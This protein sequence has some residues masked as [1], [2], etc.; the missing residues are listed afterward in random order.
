MSRTFWPFAIALA[1]ASGLS[2]LFW[3]GIDHPT[4][5]P[6]LA[7][8][9]LVL[10]SVN[11]LALAAAAVT[12]VMGVPRPAALTGGNATPRDR[13]AILWLICGEPPEPLAVRARELVKALQDRP[14]GANTQVFILS[15]TTDADA[16]ANEQ[17]LFAA[18]PGVIY[19]NRTA[20]DGRK[21]GNLRNWLERYGAEFDTMLVLDADSSF[22]A[23]RLAQMRQTMAQEPRLALL[24]AG[25]ALR[26]GS[27]RLARLQRLSVRMTGPVFTSG[28]ARLSGACGN[29]WG[30]NALLR[31]EAFRAVADLP[32]LPGRPPFGGPIL[33]HDFI[34][35]AYLRAAGWDL[36][37]CP[38]ML[39]SAEDAPTTTAA[40][41]R[42]D[43]R[44]AQGNLQHLRLIGARGLHPGSRLH[45]LAGIQ[46]YISAPIWLAL[47]LL[48]GSG[49]V[50]ARPEAWVALAATLTVLLVPKL[51]GLARLRRQ[52]AR[53]PGP[54]LRG[55]GA[56]LVLST[57]IAPI[58]MLR[59]AG[60]VLSVLAG[61][62]GGW[63]PSGA[64]LAPSG[65][66][67]RGAQIAGL[68]ILLAVIF[69]QAL[70]ASAASA[71]LSAAMV[72]PVVGPLLAAPWLLAWL[73]DLAR[74]NHVAAYYDASTKRFL[75]VGGS[76][77]ALAIHR[78]LWA[79]GV[80][81]S[82]Q[83]AA[84][85][86]TLIAEATER[87]L[88]HPPE[89][90]C[91][92]G[93]GVGG[94]MFHLAHLWPEAR[95]SGLTLSAEQVRLARSHARAQG[96]SDR[97][98]FLQADF[99]LHASL[100]KAEVAIAVESHVHAP[101]AKAFLTAALDHL[102]PGGVL[103]LV[104]DMLAEERTLPPRHARLIDSFRKG[105]RLGHVSARGQIA[106]QAEALGYA[107]LAE[108]D[109]SAF[110]HLTRW[111][112]RALR[113][114]GP[115]A[116]RFGLHH[117]PLFANMIGG[118]ALTE[119]YRHGLMRY[120]LLVLRAPHAARLPDDRSETAA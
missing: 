79:D 99:T 105:W 52:I 102:A 120:T 89:H 113:V 87:M 21:P 35:A 95:F 82:E 24:Q 109:L 112:D 31:V 114:V 86:N 3:T 96:L 53:R 57:V 73:D 68:A 48:L 12:A 2:A 25:I 81:T 69:P 34:E 26:P 6:A 108:R 13:C 10:F 76:G 117:R 7:A 61:R 88:G 94:T 44:W 20:P 93:C 84:H 38:A 103:V 23:E 115:M 58:W 119:A 71:V 66:A 90:L 75:A 15:D 91:D 70:L 100:H 43:R 45:L 106:A 16:L 104:D 29:Y 41:T 32:A 47:V 110:L 40:Y 97:C 85:V 19:R 22:T 54:V 67:G 1:L 17:A 42:R 55:F 28:L 77:G 46:S 9:V 14:E 11:A 118:N 27:S 33:S 51:A 62:D 30:H 83:A 98:H 116:E 49:A 8:A 72:L 36:R 18:L 59:R 101:S 74:P 5:A 78:P 65:K 80:G 56:E 39:G 111:R 4:T 60:H 64:A 50:H 107:V 63:Q 37:I 92:L